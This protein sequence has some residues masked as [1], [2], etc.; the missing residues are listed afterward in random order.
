[1]WDLFIRGVFNIFK[2]K[3]SLAAIDP[4]RIP[5]HVAIIMDGNGRWAKKR[6]LPRELGHAAGEESL[7]RA[8]EIAAQLKVKYLTVYA[9]STENWKRPKTEV[10]ALMNLFIKV[11]QKRSEEMKRNGVEV[12][13][14]GR[15]NEFPEIVQQAIKEAEEKTKGG[16]RLILNV[17]LNY[18][19]QAEITDAVRSIVQ[20]VVDNK[21]DP[22]EINEQVI[23]EH[24]YTKGIPEPELLIR[25]SGELRISNYLLWQMAYTEYYFTKVLWPDFREQHFV[26]AVLEYQLRQRRKGDIG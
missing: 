15:R 8:V 22:K 26:E 2:K 9:F 4:D 11:V 19:G 21:L 3:V 14:L 18:G 20:E 10:N 25:T 5:Q 16:G 17:M 1:M 24:L 6:G 12:R 13:I 23:A 7:K